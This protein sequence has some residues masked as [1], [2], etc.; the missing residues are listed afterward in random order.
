MRKPDRNMVKLNAKKAA[1]AVTTT[2]APL[3]SVGNI[4][5]DKII[6]V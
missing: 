2:P 3:A 5:E 6:E 4:G 1:M